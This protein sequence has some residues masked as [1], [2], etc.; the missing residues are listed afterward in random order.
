[1]SATLPGGW[2]SRHI[3]NRGAGFTVAIYDETKAH[4]GNYAFTGRYGDP[5][6][7]TA[8]G[9]MFTTEAEAA[10]EAMEHR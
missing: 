8:N 6:W 3:T 2:K 5:Q 9:L 1:M 7:W 4:V 10:A